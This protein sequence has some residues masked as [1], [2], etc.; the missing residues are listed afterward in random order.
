MMRREPLHPQSEVLPI[1]ER[2]ALFI[3]DADLGCLRPDNPL[4]TTNGRAFALLFG[5]RIGHSGRPTVHDF[6]PTVPL[7]GGDQKP[8]LPESSRLSC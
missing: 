8:W 3:Q 6:G 2:V 1:I 4:F 7:Q 5:L